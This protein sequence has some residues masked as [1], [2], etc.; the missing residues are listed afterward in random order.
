[1]RAEAYVCVNMRTF[2]KY[3]IK[4]ALS[5]KNIDYAL[6]SLTQQVIQAEVAK[7]CR[8]HRIALGGLRVGKAKVLVWLDA[9]RLLS[10]RKKLAVEVAGAC[11]FPYSIRA[12]EKGNKK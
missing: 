10:V 6:D 9:W 3:S 8:N 12:C 11:S 2:K 4:S 7:E 5:L 1:M